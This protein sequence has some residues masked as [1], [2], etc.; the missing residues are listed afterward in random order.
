MGIFD[1]IL[2]HLSE[3]ADV[4]NVM[5]DGSY[6]R[7]HQHSSGGS[8]GQKKTKSVFRAVGLRQKSMSSS[9]DLE[10]LCTFIFPPETSMTSQKL[11][12]LSP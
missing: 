8:G 12:Y 3:D 10:T 11:Q 7:V 2:K 4:E 6:V 5:I 9:M 1:A